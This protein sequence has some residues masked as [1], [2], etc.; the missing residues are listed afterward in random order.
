VG[1]QAAE[2]S[3]KTDDPIDRL[4]RLEPLISTIGHTV[5]A[6]VAAYILGL[7]SDRQTKDDRKPDCRS[8][9]S[10]LLE[11]HQSIAN[12]DTASATVRVPKRRPP[13][14]R[15]PPRKP[16]KKPFPPSPA[17][18]IDGWGSLDAWTYSA[19]TATAVIGAPDAQLTQEGRAMRISLRILG[20][21]LIGL[22]LLRIRGRV[23]R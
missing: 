12:G 10:H 13:S 6:S 4:Y 18:V 15:R 3:E 20:P 8:R 23:K 16:P 21:I 19:G 17:D 2:R 7:S 14:S 22:G 1:R 5:V 11:F 9:R